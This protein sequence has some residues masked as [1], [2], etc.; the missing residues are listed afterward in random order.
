MTAVSP[1]SAGRVIVTRPAAQ[2]EALCALLTAAGFEPLCHPTIAVE[3][4]DD[5]SALDAALQRLSTYH[6][7]VLPSAN[8]ARIV[9]ARAA[10]LGIWPA[11]WRGAKIVAGPQTAAVLVPHGVSALSLIHI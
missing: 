6:Y 8:A 1:M 4:L 9:C 3:P 2:S 5:L 11:S 10:R 7:V